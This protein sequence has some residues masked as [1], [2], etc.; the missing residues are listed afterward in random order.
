MYWNPE[1]ETLDAESV[2]RMQSRKLRAMLR[3]AYHHHPFYR[4]LL[5]SR[6]IDPRDIAG[7]DDLRKLPFTTQ[8]DLARDPEAFVLPVPGGKQPGR[9]SARMQVFYD[10]MVDG[11][12]TDRRVYEYHPVIAFESLGWR[13]PPYRVYMAAYDKAIFKELCGRAAMCSGLSKAD[14]LLNTHHPGRGISFWST[15]QECLSRGACCSSPGQPGPEEDALT[16][17]GLQPT[18]ISGSPVYLYYLARA[19]RRLGTGLGSLEKAYLSGCPMDAGLRGKLL[20]QLRQ[21]GA[22]PA[23]YEQYAVT[24]ARHCLAEC[25]PGSGFHTSPDVHAWECVDP[26]TGEQVGPGEPGE[27]AFTTID[28]RGSVLLRYRTGD[29]AEGGIVY[30]SCTR[31]G[32]TAPRIAGPLRRNAPGADPLRIARALLAVDGIS[33]VTVGR[34]WQGSTAGTVVRVVPEGPPSDELYGRVRDACAIDGHQ[35]T[36]V[37]EPAPPQPGLPGKMLY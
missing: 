30:D 20:S 2:A 16:C 24:E 26:A 5:R 22:E 10:S 17:A 28:G 21:A 9:L 23:L 34:A 13:T 6:G 8:A 29:V 31:C 7:P 19:A 32:R 36:V 33:H 11:N 4:P 37:F 27:L 12:K 25:A 1:I 3:M 18:A 15:V 35:L 14:R